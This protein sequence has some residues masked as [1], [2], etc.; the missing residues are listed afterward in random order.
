MLILQKTFEPKV[1]KLTHFDGL[2]FG[3]QKDC[4]MLVINDLSWQQNR[5]ILMN[6]YL[7]LNKVIENMSDY[8]HMPI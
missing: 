4:H 8:L 2:K 6:K 7:L 1:L 5:D 3:F